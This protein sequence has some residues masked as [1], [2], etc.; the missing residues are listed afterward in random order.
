MDCSVTWNS[1]LIKVD[2]PQIAKSDVLKTHMATRTIRLALQDLPHLRALARSGN[3]S[4]GEH[5][6]SSLVTFKLLHPGIEP[7]CDVHVHHSI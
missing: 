2:A 5:N 7:G 1:L 3:I 4:V 6:K